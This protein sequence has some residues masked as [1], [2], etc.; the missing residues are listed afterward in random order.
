MILLLFGIFLTIVFLYIHRVNS[1]HKKE[2]FHADYVAFIRRVQQNYRDFGAIAIQLVTHT[3]FTDEEARRLRNY[4]YSIPKSKDI[5]KRSSP[6][7]PKPPAM[8]Q[9]HAATSSPSRSS[10]EA[11]P[12]ITSRTN[13]QGNTATTTP[14]ALSSRTNSALEGQLLLS[15]DASFRVDSARNQEFSNE[16][17]V[18]NRNDNDNRP[19]SREIL[20][21]KSAAVDIPIFQESETDM[22]K[23]IFQDL[24]RWFPALQLC[25]GSLRDL[26]SLCFAPMTAFLTLHATS[27]MSF[28][29][30]YLPRLKTILLG[31]RQ[32]VES[33]HNDTL[34]E[35]PDIWDEEVLKYREEEKERFK[36]EMAEKARKG[37]ERAHNRIQ[38]E[39]YQ[40]WL[41]MQTDEFRRKREHRRKM[42]IVTKQHQRERDRLIHT[43]LFHSWGSKDL[44]PWLEKALN[45]FFQVALTFQEKMNKIDE[46]KRRNVYIARHRHNQELAAEREQERHDQKLLR[47]R[48][49]K[50]AE[51]ESMHASMQELFTDNVLHAGVSQ[52]L[53]QQIF[54]QAHPHND[55]TKAKE[56]N[57]DAV[58]QVKDSSL[59]YHRVDDV[60]IKRI[61][62]EVFLPMDQFLTAKIIG[63]FCVGSK[64]PI[65]LPEQITSPIALSAQSPQQ[66]NK[67]SVSTASSKPGH[68]SNNPKAET[69]KT[70]STDN[71]KAS[72]LT[73]A[74]RKIQRQ[75]QQKEEM[76]L[77]QQDESYRVHRMTQEEKVAHCLQV[78]AREW[79]SYF[80]SLCSSYELSQSMAKTMRAVDEQC[81]DLE[82]RGR[83]LV[84]SEEQ[85]TYKR[86]SMQSAYFQSLCPALRTSCFAFCDAMQIVDRSRARRL[87][88]C[89]AS[90][91]MFQFVKDAHLR[92]SG[93]V[94]AA[95]RI[96]GFFRMILARK[97]VY[98]IIHEKFANKKALLSK[99]MKSSSS[100]R[101]SQSSSALA[102]LTS[103]VLA[104]TRA[105]LIQKKQSEEDDARRIAR[106]STNDVSTKASL[107][108]LDTEFLDSLLG[109]KGSVAPMD[110]SSMSPLQSPKNN[111]DQAP[112]PHG[113]LSIHSPE[114]V[115]ALS[116]RHSAHMLSPKSLSSSSSQRPSLLAGGLSSPKGLSAAEN[117]AG[118]SVTGFA[119]NRIM[120][121][122]MKKELAASADEMNVLGMTVEIGG[123]EENESLR[124]DDAE[125]DYDE[126]D[127]E[128]EDA[129]IV[130]DISGLSLD[131]ELKS[132]RK[133]S[134]KRRR[135]SLLKSKK[136]LASSSNSSI[137]TRPRANSSTSQEPQPLLHSSE[138]KISMNNEAVASHP[139]QKDGNNSNFQSLQGVSTS[140]IVTKPEK[141]YEEQSYH[142]KMQSFITPFPAMQ[143][144]VNDVQGESCSM[145]VRFLVASIEY[146]EDIAGDLDNAH[147][148]A[149]YRPKSRHVAS[150][151]AFESLQAT[152]SGTT[153]LF[154]SF[155][156]KA[157]QVFE[158]YGGFQDAFQC[159][160]SQF[161]TLPVVEHYSVT[162][163][164]Y[165]P[166]EDECK[167][168][169]WEVVPSHMRSK[170]AAS[171]NV[172]HSEV[173]S[174][175][176]PRM[177]P[178]KSTYANGVKGNTE[179]ASEDHAVSEETVVI[180]LPTYCVDITM[181]V[182]G[183]SPVHRYEFFLALDPKL[184]DRL[185]R[186]YSP[187]VHGMTMTVNH[188]HGVSKSEPG[189]G[190]GLVRHPHPFRATNN[191]KI[192]HALKAV[193][194]LPLHQR[195]RRFMPMIPPPSDAIAAFTPRVPFLTVVTE[196]DSNLVLGE[197]GDDPS[198]QLLRDAQHG[199]Q[200][201]DATAMVLLS[202]SQ[203]YRTLAVPAD[204]PN[205]LTLT[206]AYRSVGP[207][208]KTKASTQRLL[209][210]RTPFT[211]SA[212]LSNSHTRLVDAQG[213]SLISFFLGDERAP[214]ESLRIL[215]RLSW[216]RSHED[217]PRRTH[218]EIQRR[219]VL[220]PCKQ[221]AEWTQLGLLDDGRHDIDI[222]T[223][224]ASPAPA[225][226]TKDAQEVSRAIEL[227]Q[228]QQ[229]S[230]ELAIRR[231]KKRMAK[232]AILGDDD[233]D[234]DDGEDGD[235]VGISGCKDSI[236][237]G[238]TGSNR[239][240]SPIDRMRVLSANQRLR[241]RSVSPTSSSID[242]TNTI[243]GEWEHLRELPTTSLDSP[244]QWEDV[245]TLTEDAS[246]LLTP[247][248][249]SFLA[250][251]IQHNR[252]VLSGLTPFVPLTTS[253]TATDT[254]SSRAVV[255]S[256]HQGMNAES[257][258]TFTTTNTTTSSGS[259]SG[260]CYA[261]LDVFV[262]YRVC[263]CNS[264]G[265]GAFA[266]HAVFANLP[267]Q[268]CEYPS[269]AA[270]ATTAMGMSRDEPYRLASLLL[271][272]VVVQADGGIDRVT[273]SVPGAA[274]AAASRTGS[275][276]DLPGWQN[277]DD[278]HKTSVPK[279]SHPPHP[280]LVA[281]L[282]QQ[283]HRR[284]E[285]DVEER[286]HDQQRRQLQDMEDAEA[287]LKELL[288]Q[289]RTATNLPMDEDPWLANLV[290]QSP[291]T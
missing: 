85:L 2:E 152:S 114:R 228:R 64:K 125:V 46:E 44:I 98:P 71:D 15:R 196:N 185:C 24:C 45:H 76:I 142:N 4:Q 62:E 218:Y 190:P 162:I 69:Q 244:V 279:Q 153:P 39:R 78:L 26:I 245:F 83:F 145:K 57:D 93:E 140:K 90:A 131:A 47:Q 171:G 258:S 263:T 129:S 28:P 182:I 132:T 81:E 254:Q 237:V 14:R 180:P 183:L 149:V 92:L 139:E 282:Q 280:V 249:R 119:T 99:T 174:S 154:V 105:S 52:L 70:K 256:H 55:G 176:G 117:A 88:A 189:P 6:S 96:R 173:A 121:M 84:I 248:V 195:L 167:L 240:A 250:Y 284:E 34:Y 67:K 65:S 103:Q 16:R 97:R 123:N 36:Q 231:E 80:V 261:G 227:Q 230:C 79:P 206:V 147:R 274:A 161:A 270:A 168:L 160:R 124:E 126:E 32:K 112:L 157:Q 136:Q 273:T 30:P 175:S 9:S 5:A 115:Q 163:Q 211:T 286:R 127:D 56:K 120:M 101:M 108:G 75:K 54:Q 23:N 110:T 267:R 100:M 290:L 225:A 3:L 219:F 259:S 260:W 82:K 7:P 60:H 257:R 106:S 104:A 197:S 277:G 253:S 221:L 271:R 251:Y 159:H 102:N 236:K 33:Y 158:K 89:V 116:S 12:P 208:D 48:R 178:G 59:M 283:F 264:A 68:Q 242:A 223:A 66:S 186:Y 150:N 111:M 275:R 288:Q 138:P 215:C 241:L 289:T 107:A 17:D 165:Q 224:T 128:E 49:K 31:M 164:K 146:A 137:V 239:P 25:R 143:L 184:S 235:V 201:H 27:H 135:K 144:I 95:D 155:K 287:R 229:E 37:H 22:L 188:E 209:A 226:G 10:R 42:Q 20:G 269:V 179:Y 113:P 198:V 61:L 220:R 200:G 217:V 141:K 29:I 13:S 265:A 212:T 172:S 11:L 281:A 133:S 166:T 272:S 187:S 63:T 109:R 130:S 74:L 262:E 192:L 247:P 252:T 291:F 38:E 91:C 41:S 194:S 53:R 21:R 238:A 246:S 1:E 170:L 19:V 43:A 156:S 58:P 8:G 205:P 268:E 204:A 202:F 35:P 191:S 169:P 276:R 134:K 151:T 122:G 118:E 199:H 234:D 216:P 214:A 94:I 77:M 232:K 181:T 86:N 73:P 213:A 255:P 87:V 266:R 18:L 193:D 233:D 243:V 207:V 177:I 51:E 72:A 222:D 210:S 50:K 285:A 40:L 278:D 203:S 148:V